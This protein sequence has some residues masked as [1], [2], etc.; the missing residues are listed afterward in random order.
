MNNLEKSTVKR[1]VQGLS[2]LELTTTVQDLGDTTSPA[3]SLGVD[4]GAMVQTLV[5]SVGNRYVLVLTAGGSTCQ[6][7]QLSRAFGLDGSVVRPTG[8][9]VRAVT[10]FSIGGVSPVGLVAKLPV[11]I[12]GNLKK[13]EKIYI[14]A[15]DSACV[16]ESNMDELK[17]LTGGVVSYAVAK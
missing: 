4:V 6:E 7:D 15:G 10:G 13:Y 9:L 11:A 3:A 12:D 2:D 1:V 14:L 16:F 8:D 5:Y 17:K